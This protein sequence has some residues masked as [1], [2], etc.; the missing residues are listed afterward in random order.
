MADLLEK[1]TSRGLLVE[2]VI[3]LV[4]PYAESKAVTDSL[5]PLI[6]CNVGEDRPTLVFMSGSDIGNMNMSSCSQIKR[7]FQLFTS[8]E[9]LKT[10]F[11]LVDLV[12]IF[13]E[14]FIPLLRNF[15]S[16]F[17]PTFLANFFIRS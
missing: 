13:A 8:S 4:D 12:L 16:S 7:N 3:E 15:T 14:I 2:F 11:G 5:G 6:L 1:S 9:V 17:Y 10:N